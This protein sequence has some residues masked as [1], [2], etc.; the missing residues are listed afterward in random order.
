M[1]NRHKFSFIICCAIVDMI[2]MILGTIIFLNFASEESIGWNALFLNKMIPITILS[3]LFSVTYF[4]LYRV[5]VLFSLDDFF[6][7]S[8]RSFFAQR[9]KKSKYGMHSRICSCIAASG[10][11][12][13]SQLE[14]NDAHTHHLEVTSGSR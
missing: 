5:D 7:N 10:A 2:A 13:A 4:Q 6:R 1:R 8:W 14:G 11:T 12:N 9:I 3:W